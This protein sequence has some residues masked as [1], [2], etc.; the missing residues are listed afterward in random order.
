MEPEGLIPFSQKPTQ[1]QDT[2]LH[3]KQRR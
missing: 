2:I 1:T 3:I